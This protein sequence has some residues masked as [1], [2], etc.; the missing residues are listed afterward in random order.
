MA[1]KVVITNAAMRQFDRYLGYV[2]HTLQNKQAARNILQD[3]RQTVKELST[4][5]GSMKLMNGP[6]LA[7]RGYRK[8][9]F[10]KHNYLMIY[11][12]EDNTAIVDAIFHT[13]QDYENAL[14]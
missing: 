7:K 2:V 5:A 13:L 8:L 1:Y 14:R 4:T 12:I 10:Q 3:F 6:D 9:N 11:R